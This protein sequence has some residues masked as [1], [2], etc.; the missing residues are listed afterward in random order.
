MGLGPGP[1]EI[2]TMSFEPTTTS[3]QF[4]RTR[5]WIYWRTIHRGERSRRK[6]RFEDWRQGVGCLH[7]DYYRE[8]SIFTVFPIYLI[9]SEFCHRPSFHDSFTLGST[10][11][12]SVYDL[13]DVS[14]RVLFVGVSSG[15][16]VGPN[17]LLSLLHLESRLV[18]GKRR[19]ELRC[20]TVRH[21]FEVILIKY[22]NV[23]FPFLRVRH[24]PWISF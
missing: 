10:G 15:V 13:L 1:V 19:M 2:G 22:C 17:V 20:W 7:P 16:V 21:T 6:N 24:N 12:Q 8:W 11:T 14:G 5:P 4:I 9:K 23:G 18:T 3:S